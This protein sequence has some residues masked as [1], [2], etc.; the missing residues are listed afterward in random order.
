MVKATHIRSL[1]Q[2]PHKKRE[3]E[4]G[5]EDEEWREGRA[6]RVEKRASSSESWSTLSPVLLPLPSAWDDSTP[7]VS[8]L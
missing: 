5:R 4:T 7:L 1:K 2:T 8:L 6:M 3:T